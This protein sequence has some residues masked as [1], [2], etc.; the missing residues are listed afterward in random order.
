LKKVSLQTP[1]Q[2]TLMKTAFCVVFGEFF[3]GYFFIHVGNCMQFP[4][5]SEAKA[6]LSLLYIG[7]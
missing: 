4:L 7:G 3:R 5:V 1:L 6:T 2:K